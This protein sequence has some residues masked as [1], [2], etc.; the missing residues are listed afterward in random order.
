MKHYVFQHALPLVVLS[1]LHALPASANEWKADSASLAQCRQAVY[2][3][4]SPLDRVAT[5]E[6]APGR[7]AEATRVD[8][9]H[10]GISNRCGIE[11]VEDKGYIRVV[12]FE[13]VDPSKH[14]QIKLQLWTDREGPVVG[15]EKFE[16]I[17]LLENDPTYAEGRIKGR[18]SC[19]LEQDTVSYRTETPI[20]ADGVRSPFGVTV[21]KLK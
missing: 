2:E 10:L 18:I 7:A 19:R 13:A 15:I 1:V 8:S 20:Y 3:A 17:K 14:R 4:V 11:V 16:T 6:L 5:R 21:L 12:Q 9:F